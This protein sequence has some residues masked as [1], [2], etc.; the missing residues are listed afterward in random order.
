MIFPA[1]SIAEARAPA[2]VKLRSSRSPAG[3]SRPSDLCHRPGRYQTERSRTPRDAVAA[4]EAVAVRSPSGLTWQMR[5]FDPS[6]TKLAMQ[7]SG[8][9]T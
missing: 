7:S 8:V 3:W 4:V 5:R 6:Y 1:P 2:L 9:V